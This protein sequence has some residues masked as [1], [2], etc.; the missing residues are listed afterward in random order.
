VG[1]KE[2]KPWL[3]GWIAGAIPP[4]GLEKS[5]NRLLIDIPDAEAASIEPPAERAHDSKSIFDTV[6]AI[7]PF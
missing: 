6:R 3:I 5:G 4:T 1:Q 2:P 7:P